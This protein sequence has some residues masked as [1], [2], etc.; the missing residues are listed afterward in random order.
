MPKVSFGSQKCVYNK[1]DPVLRELQLLELAGERHRAQLD[2]ERALLCPERELNS[3]RRVV[4]HVW[5][6]SG[7]AFVPGA[8]SWP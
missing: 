4:G 2:S 3:F 7:D 5:L 8:V 6:W 1:T